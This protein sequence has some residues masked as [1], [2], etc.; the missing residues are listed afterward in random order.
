MGIQY[1]IPYLLAAGVLFFLYLIEDRKLRFLTRKT[2]IFTAYLFL[3][4]FIGLRGHIMSDFISYY[5]YF[6]EYPDIFSLNAKSLLN[7]FEPGFNI[8]TAL[9]KT[10]CGNY[11]AWVA[12]NTL[13][14]LLVLSWF[15]KRYCKSMI[16]PL[17]FFVAFNG[18]LMEFNL[19]RNMKAIDLFLLSMPYLQKR[20][21]L[22]YFALNLIGIS[23]HSSA[24][25]YLPLYFCLNL[26]LSKIV[27]WG[28][29]MVVN[30]LYFINFRFI[31]DLISHISFVRELT[32]YDKIIG[33]ASSAEEFKFSVGYFERTISFIIFSLL[34]RSLYKQNKENN[35]F[36]NCFWIYYCSFLLFFEVSV[37]VERIPT[38]FSF[39]YW[40]L[41][42]NVVYCR[43]K[44]SRF[45]EIYLALLVVMK[46]CTSYGTITS[47]Y[48][49]ILFNTP[50]FNTQRT[51]FLQEYRKKH[52]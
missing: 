19:Y 20:R 32:A 30:L 38:L 42:S 22:P 6:E 4:L 9:F 36:F 5:P 24:F 26:K 37:F 17:I 46:I 27:I 3:W 16:L 15:F 18:L 52:R 12:F 28:S 25:I 33:Y 11:F 45:I 40:V 21:F 1:S 23:F 44:S 29:F 48:Q 49:N 47:K 43:F 39:S 8:Y 13:I 50:D 34:Y 10:F 2:A 35:I 41:F 31:S 51:L 7:N 14:D